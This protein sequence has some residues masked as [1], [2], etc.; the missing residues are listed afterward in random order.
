MSSSLEFLGNSS[1]G[2]GD[3]RYKGTKVRKSMVC[4]WGRG[5]RETHE[6]STHGVMETDK[7]RDL[8]TASWRPRILSGVI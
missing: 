2:K 5:E 8:L 3:M 7:S 4:V 6:K 1:V